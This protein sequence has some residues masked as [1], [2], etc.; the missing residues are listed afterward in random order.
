[1]VIPCGDSLLAAFVSYIG[2][3]GAEYRLELWSQMWL[4]DMQNREIPCTEGID[5]LTVI[6]DSGNNAK[7]MSEGLPADRMSIE[8]GAMITKCTRWPLIIDPQEQGIKWLRRQE[9]MA[10]ERQHRRRKRRGGGRRRVDG[11]IRQRC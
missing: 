9:T 8:N 1:M 2:A 10:V 11:G 7:M 3:F 4:P 5:P 6:T